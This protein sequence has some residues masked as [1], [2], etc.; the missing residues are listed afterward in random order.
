MNVQ[1]KTR[2]LIKLAAAATA[3]NSVPPPQAAPAPV[4]SPTPDITQVRKPL[5]VQ[6]KPSTQ[7][8]PPIQRAGAKSAAKAV[9][10]IKQTRM[11]AAAAV[12]PSQEPAGPKL[13]Q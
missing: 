6:P 12:F 5:A 10:Q 3:A 11:P 4:P 7:I 2:L 8:A 13:K 9:K 1:R